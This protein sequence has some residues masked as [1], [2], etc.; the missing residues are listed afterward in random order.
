MISTGPLGSRLEQWVTG[1]LHADA[2]P[3]D[4]QELHPRPELNTP[5]SPPQ[6]GTEAVLAD[7]WSRVLGIEPIGSDDNFFE[8]GGHSLIAIDLTGRIRK[9]LGAAIPVT[10]LL[11]YPTVRQLAELIDSAELVDP[12]AAVDPTGAVEPAEEVGHA[13]A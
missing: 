8:L 5:F 6:E 10:G 1:D 3:D 2:A 4:N 7:I 12:V 13:P 11:E 9:A